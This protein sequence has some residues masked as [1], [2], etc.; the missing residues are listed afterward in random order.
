[1]RKV[2]KIGFPIFCIVVIGGTF[3]LLNRTV[4]K[5]NENGLK[6]KKSDISTE[7]KTDDNNSFNEVNQVSY[8]VSM[9][10]KEKQEKSEENKKDKAVELVKQKEI[11][12]KNVYFTNEGVENGKFIVAIRDTSTTEAIIYYIVDIDTE[13][14]QIY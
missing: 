14:L 10:D 8:T 7:N 5:I 2:I 4:K 1:M 9:D 3:I 6:N 13:E 11:N 12:R